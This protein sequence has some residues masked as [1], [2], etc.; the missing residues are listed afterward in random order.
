M[1]EDIKL[2]KLFTEAKEVKGDFLHNPENFNETF[3][4]LDEFLDDCKGIYFLTIKGKYVT[5]VGMSSVS[6]KDRIYGG[7]LSEGH[8]YRKVFDSF[9]YIPLEKLDKHDIKAMES[10]FIQLFSPPENVMGRCP[11]KLCTIKEYLETT[12]EHKEKFNSFQE[13]RSMQCAVRLA[14][15]WS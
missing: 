7:G 5:Y 3:V 8:V 4:D 15:F 10:R 9:K 11:N 2:Y 13:E 12:K 14:N 1:K 6:I